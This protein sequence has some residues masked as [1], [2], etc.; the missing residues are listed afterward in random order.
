MK[1]PLHRTP[2]I[3][4][5]ALAA[6]SGAGTGPSVHVVARG[7]VARQALATGFVEPERETQ[8]NTQLA[9]YVRTLHVRP[10][11]RVAAGAPLAE[12]WPSLTEQELLRAERAVASAREGEEA[13]QEFVRGDHTL[14]YFTRLLQG[15]AN[16]GRMQRAAERGRRSAEEMLTLLREG[17]VE[18]DGRRIDFVVRSPVAGH[19]LQLLR[20]GDPVTPASS[21]GLGSVVAVI[22]DLDQP[23]FR[24]SVDEIDVGRLTEG[25]PAKVRLGP[26][27]DVTL[28]GTIVEI[29]LRAKRVDNA[30]SFDVRIALKA[31]PKVPLRAGYSAV[32]EL[33]LARADDVVVVPE[34]LLRWQ[35]GRAFVSVVGA[36]GTAQERELVLGV[37]DGLLAEVK[38]GLAEGER[39]AER[40]PDRR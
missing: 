16:L 31:D 30:T 9:G 13:A 34:R 19:V 21:Y 39:V 28:A 15:E 2:G 35:D 24:G 7:D 12:V 32:A 11:Q 26:L 5:L 37:A 17:A 6:C 4:L 14:A 18:I 40:G 20:E 1:H 22:G 33:E 29:G 38:S 23:V 3:C 8:V 36:E 27:P 10:G 25:M